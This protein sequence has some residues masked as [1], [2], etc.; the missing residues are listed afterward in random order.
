M[1]G[2]YAIA[3]LLFASLACM[4]SSAV[5]DGVRPEASPTVAVRDLQA[6]TPEAAHLDEMIVEGAGLPVFDTGLIIRTVCAIESLNVRGGP[7]TNW[8]VLY[9]LPAG[10]RVRVRDVG[11]GVNAGWLMIS[12]LQYDPPYSPQWVNGDYLCP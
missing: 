5:G 8:A 9:V 4:E 1:K 7:G 6:A 12:R 10:E 11:M 3:L 2:I